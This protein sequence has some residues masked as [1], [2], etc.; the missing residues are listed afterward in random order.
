MKIP[1][2]QHELARYYKRGK[3]VSYFL[4]NAAKTCLYGLKISEN[5]EIGYFFQSR[6]FS[7][8]SS[9]LHASCLSAF[10][11]KF[12]DNTDVDVPLL[13]LGNVWNF[14][15]PL[16]SSCLHILLYN[17]CPHYMPQVNNKNT[18]TR[19]KICSKL[20]RKTSLMSL[21]TLIHS[22]LITDYYKFYKLTNFT[23]ILQFFFKM[24]VQNLKY[25]IKGG[26]IWVWY[27]DIWLHWYLWEYSVIGNP[28]DHRSFFNFEA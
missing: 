24:Y 22:Y 19:F 15:Y 28:F 7:H 1:K 12:H 23:N 4:N 27:I 21:I 18:R 17:L 6:A 10:K 16:T 9:N 5:I 2:W 8:L 11:G 13:T 25:N 14:L 26:Y 20:K 3:L